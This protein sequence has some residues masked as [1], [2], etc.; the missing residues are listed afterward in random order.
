M[1]L[2]K[3]KISFC[4]LVEGN[5]MGD[6]QGWCDEEMRFSLSLY[7]CVDLLTHLSQSCKTTKKNFDLFINTSTFSTHTFISLSRQII[8]KYVMIKSTQAYTPLNCSTLFSR[9]LHRPPWTLRWDRIRPVVWN[10]S[11]NLTP[12]WSEFA[13]V[14]RFSEKANDWIVT[15]YRIVPAHVLG[16]S[17][18]T[19]EILQHPTPLH[20]QVKPMVA[21]EKRQVNKTKIKNNKYKKEK[22]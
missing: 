11:T 2:K 6:F 8:T 12:S 1:I 4:L 9:S 15:N 22:I 16:D 3:K 7:V 20:L 18:A 14:V 5:R 17:K 13:P 10:H 21:N 19:A